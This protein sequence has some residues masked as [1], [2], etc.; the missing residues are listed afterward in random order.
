MYCQAS[1]LTRKLSVAE[2]SMV[3]LL[4]TGGMARSIFRRSAMK[5][6]SKRRSASS[7]T[8]MA[9]SLNPSLPER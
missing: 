4:C 1:S 9:I 5:P 7:M 8:R 3:C 6:M 2:K